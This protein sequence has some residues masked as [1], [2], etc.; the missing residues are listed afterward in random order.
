M[1][2]SFVPVAILRPF[3]AVEHHYLRPHQNM[4]GACA[5]VR[6]VWGDGK[7]CTAMYT[8]LLLN[9]GTI[10]IACVHTLHSAIDNDHNDNQQNL[11]H[12][13]QQLQNSA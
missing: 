4:R 11:Y 1:V 8:R 2:P 12:L 9:I 7:I 5:V 10:K 13:T 6:W 3:L